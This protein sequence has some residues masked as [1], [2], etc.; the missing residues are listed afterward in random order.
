MGRLDVSTGFGMAGSDSMIFFMGREISIRFF[1][2][3][4]LTISMRGGGVA[5]GSALRDWHVLFIFRCRDIRKNWV[6]E[7]MGEIL[8]QC[9]YPLIAFPFPLP[10]GSLGERQDHLAGC[11][12]VGDDGEGDGR[13]ADGILAAVNIF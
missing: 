5:S 11:T 7:G 4:A 2:G 3:G 8:P 12:G 10:S 13:I 9:F 1:W 6:F